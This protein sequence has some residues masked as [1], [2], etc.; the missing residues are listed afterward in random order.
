MKQGKIIEPAKVN[1]RPHERSTA[2]AIARTGMVVEFVIKSEYT[3]TNSA[4]LL[5]D[6]IVWEMK[7][8]QTDKWTQLEKNLKRA[9]K[10]SPYII[11]DS[12]RVKRMQD[13]TIQ[14][15]LIAKFKAN[16]SIKRLLF[17]NRRRE[18]I[19]ISDLI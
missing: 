6:G 5:I 16:K 15:F 9:S 8:P 11:I 12:Q 18:V 4:D 14:N 17:V 10:Q 7:S 2:R 13:R 1:I 19:D 3:H